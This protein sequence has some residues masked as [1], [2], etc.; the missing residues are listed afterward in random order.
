MRWA[1]GRRRLRWQSVSVELACGLAVLLLGRRLLEEEDSAQVL[2]ALPP[3]EARPFSVARLIGFYY[4]VWKNRGCAQARHYYAV[5]ALERG[6]GSDDEV[7]IVSEKPPPSKQPASAAVAVAAVAGPRPGAS[8]R[9]Q[10]PPP[11]AA[12]KPA[13]PPPPSPPPPLHARPAP[14]AST[15]AAV[16]SAPA[17][18]NP[19]KNVEVRERGPVLNGQGKPGMLRAPPPEA[20]VDAARAFARS[21]TQLSAA[22]SQ[23]QVRRPGLAAQ[24]RPSA[25]NYKSCSAAMKRAADHQRS[26]MRHDIQ[27]AC[28]SIIA[29]RCPVW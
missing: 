15:P 21:P 18:A 16:A 11:Q 3:R 9:S 20:L 2:G 6:G 12:R 27:A 29:L 13:P 14:P 24:R 7:L 10:P 26:S 19:S 8:A 28:G 1:S 5:R 22:C 4:N 17:R 25:T 23:S